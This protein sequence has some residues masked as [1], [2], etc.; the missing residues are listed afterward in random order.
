MTPD[1][2]PTPLVTQ[3]PE[4]MPEIFKT[5]PPIPQGFSDAELMEKAKGEISK[6]Q[7]AS[8]VEEWID[9]SGEELGPLHNSYFGYGYFG[10]RDEN[11]KY[12]KVITAYDAEGNKRRM[13]FY[14]D[15]KEVFS[16]AYS[17]FGTLTSAGGA[18]EQEWQIWSPLSYVEK[19][20]QGRKAAEVRFGDKF[21]Y[22]YDDEGRLTSRLSFRGDS[23]HGETIYGYD[24]NG[25]LTSVNS[26]DEAGNLTA[27]GG[28]EEYAYT[29]DEKGR[30]ASVTY[31]RLT[32][33]PRYEFKYFE[34][35]PVLVTQKYWNGEEYVLD[36]SAYLFLPSTEV[37]NILESGKGF[38]FPDGVGGEIKD[39]PINDST[40][41][42]PGLMDAQFEAKALEY[43]LY[44][45]EEGRFLARISRNYD[46]ESFEDLIDRLLELKEFPMD[47]RIW[48]NE[49]ATC[50]YAEDRLTYYYSY[51]GG[52]GYGIEYLEYDNDGRL[53]K[54]T[55]NGG[56][57]SCYEIA[58]NN[59][60]HI[61][62]VAY[63]NEPSGMDGDDV[64]AVIT[65]TYTYDKDGKLSA[66]KG[67]FSFEYTEEGYTQKTYHLTYNVKQY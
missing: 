33:Y 37:R 23:F 63:V 28:N 49:G 61:S 17:P 57:S 20:A 11:L 67:D 35:G 59:V 24:A 60:G 48:T 62:E 4:D 42:W 36:Y 53:T 16:A 34:N 50:E 39:E 66:M 54:R 65:V 15:D 5:M 31:G 14:L 32:R 64:R 30:I 6:V 8:Y 1:V 13:T 26:Y 46:G 43:C 51:G 25:N 12:D 9:G 41:N 47:E 18:K 58:Y 27:V 21:F 22:A 56:G 10:C 55:V 7:C 40:K 44:P 3:E 52:G 29:W 38:V 19:D 2:Q 45:A